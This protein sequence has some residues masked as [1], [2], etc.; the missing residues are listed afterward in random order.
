MFQHSKCSD[1]FQQEVQDMLRST[2]GNGLLVRT[3]AYLGE[4]HALSSLVG[5]SG[6]DLVGE[7]SGK[8]FAFH[9]HL[10]ETEILGHRV[11]VRGAMKIQLGSSVSLAGN[12]V[13]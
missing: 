2:K 11:R 6:L 7:V 12:L 13:R 10:S 1:L 5:K 8:S 4:D 9:A 3:K